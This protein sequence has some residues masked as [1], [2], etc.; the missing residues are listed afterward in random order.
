M[1]RRDGKDE[2]PGPE[3]DPRIDWRGEKCSNE[4]H[5]SPQDP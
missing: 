3:R 4:T 5:V 2:P 1:R